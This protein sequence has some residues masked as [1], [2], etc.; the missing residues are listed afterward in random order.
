MHLLK[1]TAFEFLF[2]RLTPLYFLY[3]CNTAIVSA[4]SGVPLMENLSREFR[5]KI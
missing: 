1:L 4:K 5:H 3:I 2:H